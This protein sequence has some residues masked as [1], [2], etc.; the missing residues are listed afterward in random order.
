M[1]DSR[2]VLPACAIILGI[3][4]VQ[5]VAATPKSESLTIKDAKG[6]VRVRLGETTKGAFGWQVLDEAGVVVATFSGDGAQSSMKLGPFGGRAA[7]SLSVSG[8]ESV[9]EMSHAGWRAVLS[10][11]A[12]GEMIC[13][14]YGGEGDKTVPAMTVGFTPGEGGGARLR[15]GNGK[16]TRESVFLSAEHGG[17]GVQL[18][19]GGKVRAQLATN[20]GN[21]IG[22]LLLGERLKGVFLQALDSGGALLELCDGLP[23]VTLQSNSKGAGLGV[24]QEDGAPAIRIGVKPSGETRMDAIPK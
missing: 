11:D 21:G 18:S 3:A 5:D 12:S 17:A 24:D 19:S 8:Q 6:N 1:L 15:L 16:D 23:R 9:L 10:Q 7:L 20:G 2:L 4:A 22:Y 14:Y 13:G